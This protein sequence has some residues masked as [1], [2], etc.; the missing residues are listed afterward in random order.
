MFRHIIL[1]LFI[2]LFGAFIKGQDYSYQLLQQMIGEASKIDAATY[3]VD[4]EERMDGEMKAGASDVKYKRYPYSI[5]VKQKKGVEVLYVDGFNHGKAL[6]NPGGFPWINIS[7]DPMGSIMRK[8]QHHTIHEAGFDMIIAIINKLYKK[9]RPKVDKTSDILKYEGII[10]KHG[11]IYYKLSFKNLDYKIID[12]KMKEDETVYEVAK[13]MLIPAYRVIELNDNISEYHDVKPGMTVRIPND[14][15]SEIKVLM[16]KK[17]SLPEHI[18]IYDENGLFEI[19]DF[20]NV[21][22]NPA[23]DSD[24]FS[25]S[26]KDYKF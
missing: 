23:F 13:R 11:E 6:I 18:E 2:G 14:Y 16:S 26:Y 5:Y 3:H 15:A 4:K 1:L 21:I 7:L 22:I 12:Y 17:T 24:E 25:K 10:N 20:S 19:F 8:G 9:Y